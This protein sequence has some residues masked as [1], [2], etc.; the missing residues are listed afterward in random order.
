MLYGL[1]AALPFILIQIKDMVIF[2]ARC[3]A[4]AVYAVIKVSVSM[5][6]YPSHTGIV[7]K[8]LNVGSRKQHRTIA[9]GF[10]VPM[11]DRNGKS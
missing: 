9:H 11:Y 2:T 6:V 4:S 10:L 8:W 3:Y 5:F 7:S 1:I